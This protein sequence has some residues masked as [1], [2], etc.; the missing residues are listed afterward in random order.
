MLSDFS[1]LF[2]PPKIFLQPQTIFLVHNQRPKKKEK[3][4]IFLDFFLFIVELREFS[5][6]DAKESSNY[7]D[8]WLG[9]FKDDSD[10]D[11]KS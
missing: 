6:R 4:R 3:E 8:F 5:E 1:L 11:G 9:D 10:N 2:F 7:L